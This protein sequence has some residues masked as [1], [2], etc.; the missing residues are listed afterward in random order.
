MPLLG[1]A[2]GGWT[3]SS[4]ALRLLNAGVRNSV[5]ELTDDAF[6]QTNPTAVATNVSTQIN[7]AVIGVVSGSVAFTR[8][9][10]GSNFIGGPG[11]AAIQALIQADVAEAIGYHP[12][13]VF[14]NSANGQAFENTPGVASGKGPYMCAQGTYGNALYETAL[15]G[16]SIGGDPAAGAAI[17]YV[18]GLKLI[19]SRNGLLTPAEQLNG[20]G[21]AIVSCDDVTIAAQSFV[22]NTD[23][24]SDLIAVLKMPPDA[25]QTE[26]V[27]DQR[28]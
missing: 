15:I 16:N 17:A 6:T 28:I 3:E 9:D 23:N 24:S 11:S 13:G 8:P 19:A 20:A 25:V 27:Y 1:Q 7:T 14:I 22:R 12:L 18:T 4:T 10:V 5:G 21:A 26:L 2:S